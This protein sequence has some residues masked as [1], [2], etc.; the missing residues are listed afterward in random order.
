[1]GKK[2]TNQVESNID[3]ME[4]KKKEKECK[5]WVNNNFVK[6]IC[7][8]T[9]CECKRDGK[10]YNLSMEFGWSEMDYLVESRRE[11]NENEIERNKIFGWNWHGMECN[12][13][14]IEWNGSGITM[15]NA[16]ITT[17]KQH[18]VY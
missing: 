14:G 15:E 4:W 11:E 13:S 16:I 18:N 3:G 8:V 17:Y 5:K 12:A 10:N 7:N 1:M 9:E 6:W 2:M